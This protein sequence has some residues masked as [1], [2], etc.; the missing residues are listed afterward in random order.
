MHKNINLKDWQVELEKAKA[1]C[2]VYERKLFTSTM[3]AEF[4]HRCMKRFEE[5]LIQGN[6]GNYCFY[7]ECFHRIYVD[8][9]RKG[10]YYLGTCSFKEGIP[11]QAEPAT[12]ELLRLP[13]KVKLIDKSLQ[14]LSDEEL[15]VILCNDLMMMTMTS[16]SHLIGKNQSSHH[17]CRCKALDTMKSYI[18]KETSLETQ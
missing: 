7:R 13:T 9:C 8:L 5:W 1:A 17:R 6:S 4:N 18:R 2:R 14:L 11:V 10:S 3:K 12:P 16:I 15:F